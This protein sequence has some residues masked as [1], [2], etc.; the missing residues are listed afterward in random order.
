ML[1]SVFLGIIGFL[2][3]MFLFIDNTKVNKSVDL[4][5][6]LLDFDIK[7]FKKDMSYLRK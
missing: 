3:L 2:M 4:E 5:K 7:M 1:L 6:E